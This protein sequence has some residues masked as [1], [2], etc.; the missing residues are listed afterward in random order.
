MTAPDAPRSEDSLQVELD[1]LPRPLLVLSTAVGR[2]MFS[3]GEALLERAEGRGRV[4]HRPIEDFLPSAG[5]REDVQRYRTISSRFPVLLNIAYRFP[6]IYQR[7]L[8]R[9]RHLRT[10]DLGRLERCLEGYRA[11]LA[12]SH[13]A[14]FWAGLAKERTGLD[15]TL[16]GL[17]GE[18]GSSLGWRY[19]PWSALQGFLSPVPRADIRFEIPATVAFREVAL[20]ARAEYVRLAETAGDRRAVLVVC[21]YWGQGRID[22]VLAEL[23][24]ERADLELHAVCGENAAMRAAIAA[25]G[26][27]RVHAHGVVPS[28]VP[29]LARC[30]S[31][32]SKPGIAAILE[33]HAA[34]RALF[35]MR[36]MPVAED[37]NLRYALAH[38][39]AQPYSLRRFLE[40][41]EE[42]PGSKQ[43][44]SRRDDPQPKSA[45]CP[46]SAR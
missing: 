37:N 40:W 24:A 20:P 38:G 8:L 46:A 35:L 39:W 29:L 27:A 22:R 7:K 43:D 41:L 16:V 9:E 42:A 14:A 11:V 3:I 10:T 33:V 13:R 6:P 5:L 12:V 4:D 30:G 44:G 34:R 28:L 17:S 2:G 18:F 36:G 32:I 19:V 31:V 23:R 26:D 21:G 45:P 15:V 1:L 25:A